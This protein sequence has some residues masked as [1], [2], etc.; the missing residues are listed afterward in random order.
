MASRAK[1]QST[2]LQP[3]CH[4][5]LLQAIVVSENR[6]ALCKMPCSNAHLCME[7]EA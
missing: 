7:V 4:Q 3:G 5:A 1:V 2:E 6:A